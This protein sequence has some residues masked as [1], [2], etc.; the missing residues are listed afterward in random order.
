MNQPNFLI[1]GGQKCGSTA[2]YDALRRHPDIY[3]S[4]HKEPKFFALA[5]TPATFGR[6]IPRVMITDWEEYLHLFDGATGQKALGEASAIYLSHY[7]PARTAAHIRARIPAA[8]LIAVLR[9]P[10]DRAYSAYTYF[11]SIGAERL[12]TF[13]AALATES[14]CAAQN[15]WPGL[16]YRLNGFYYANLKPYYDHFPAEQIRVYLY[17]DWTQQPQAMLQDIFRFLEVDDQVSVQARR[18]RVTTA[19]RIRWLHRYLSNP[20]G[21]KHWPLNLLPQPWQTRIIRRLQAWNQQP[22]APLAPEIRR[23]LTEGYRDDI[24]QLQTLIGRDL[25]HWLQ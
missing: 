14:T 20:R 22:P 16:H 3:M 24:L 13:A 23:T 15:I 7:Y 21:M 9:Q 8:K 1:I 18:R 11:Y 6:G 12:P 2:L 4:P 5:A 10:A 25:S 19:P 17:E